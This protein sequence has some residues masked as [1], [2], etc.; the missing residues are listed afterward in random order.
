MKFHVIPRPKAVGIRF[1]CMAKP[2]AAFGGKRYGL[3][4]GELAEGQERP[5]WGATSLRTGLAMTWLFGF[6]V[7][8]TG[9]PFLGMRILRLRASPCA[10]D[11]AV[12]DFC[13]WKSVEMLQVWI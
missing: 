4:E 7:W 6:C 10:Q 3:P 11:D 12:L 5:P 2:C 13:A 1:P 8:K 9:H